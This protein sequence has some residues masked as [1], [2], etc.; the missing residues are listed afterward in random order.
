MND[1]LTP[2]VILPVIISVV[3][4]IIIIVLIKINHSVI[5]EKRINEFSYQSLEERN[6]S[7]FDRIHEFSWRFINKVSNILSKSSLLIKWSKHYDK[8]IGYDE[9]P[10]KKSIDFISIKLLTGI[11]L[12][13]LYIILSIS[14]YTRI[15]YIYILLFFILGFMAIDIILKIRNVGNKDKL[16]NELI[17]AVMTMN[18]AFKSGR[19]ITQAIDIVGNELSGVIASEFKKISLDI[20]LGLSLEVAFTRFYERTKLS[21]AM[22]IATSLAVLSK[23]GGNITKI[24]S[25]IESSFL[26]HKKMKN[27]LDAAT[28]ASKLVFRILVLLP[29]ILI[30]TIFILNPAYFE[31]LYTNTLG[32]MILLII[33]LLFSLY[34]FIVKRTI[35]VTRI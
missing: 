26:A 2:S 10:Y 13:F 17:N 25:S 4:L 8:Y 1:L 28:S 19:N 31:P 3:L 23:T 18:N 30:L 29:F 20:S 9:T 12:S 32:I 14:E 24:F 22:Y 6:T 11:L 21:D 27:E 5:L 33:I 34:I 7:L 35:E 15:N 16:S